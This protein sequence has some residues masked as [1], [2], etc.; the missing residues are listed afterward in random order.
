[1]LDDTEVVLEGG[2]WPCKLHPVDSVAAEQD[3]HTHTESAGLQESFPLEFR[4]RISLFWNKRGVWSPPLTFLLLLG[5]EDLHTLPDMLVLTQLLL[6][7][8]QLLDLRVAANL[9]KA[10]RLS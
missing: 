5:P 8:P 10:T 9:A 1:M 4:G 3:T 7:L 6:P 2:E